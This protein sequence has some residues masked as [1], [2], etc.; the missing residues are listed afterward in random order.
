MILLGS[1]NER[2]LCNKLKENLQNK[3]VHNL[4]GS[5]KILEIHEL[6]KNM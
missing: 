6:L 2:K 5:L 3:N 4:A 1:K